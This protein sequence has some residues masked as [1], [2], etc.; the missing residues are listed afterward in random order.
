V[1]TAASLTDDVAGWFRRLPGAADGLVVAVSGGPD[2]VAL[3]RLLAATDARLAIAHLNHQ[4]RGAESD[5]DEAFVHELYQSLRVAR[6]QA[7]TWHCERLDVAARARAE[8]GNL[9]AVARRLRYAWLAD[10]ARRE[11]L[12][13]V[14]TGHTADDQA[15]TVL[16]R[17]LRG[18]GLKGLRGIAARRALAPDVEV[19]R[20]LL[21]VRRAELVAYLAELEQGFRVDQTN[22]DPRFTRSRIRYELMPLLAQRY[23]LAIVSV[24]C[25]LADEAAAAYS[26]REARA[27][28]LLAQAERPR[29]GAVV[30]LD[31]RRLAR[32]PRP[33][34]REALRLLWDREGWPARGMN[35][36]SW[37]RLAGLSRG[38]GVAADLPDGIRARATERVL[39]LH[40]NL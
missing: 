32:A 33:L 3:T 15:E 10:V 23:N 37:E 19:V 24:L 36:A 16:H 6:P 12:R 4:L 21:S 5:C 28:A 20:P 2:S 30:V 9:E 34:V 18:T 29:A 1:K 39:R 38:E 40:R 31:R 13:F 35:F 26:R 22:R 8:G 14:A 27:A 17:L 25:R 11:G 7:V